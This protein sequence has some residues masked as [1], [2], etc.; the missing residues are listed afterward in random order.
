MRRQSFT[1]IV[2]AIAGLLLALAA[3][4]WVGSHDHN[5]HPVNPGGV[6]NLVAPPF[7][8][9]AYAADE[10]PPGIL[11]DFPDDEVGIAAYFNAGQTIDL[12]DVVGLYRVIETQT[13]DYILGSVPVSG[14]NEQH[15]VHLYVHTSG[16]VMVYLRDTVV[17]AR[18][19][20]WVAYNYGAVIPTKFDSVGT[21]VATTIGIA[22]PTLTYYHFSYPNANRLMLVA[23]GDTGCCDDFQ[24]ELPGTFTYFH[25]SASTWDAEMRLNG[26]T[27][28]GDNGSFAQTAIDPADMPPD[29]LHSF[30]L[31]EGGETEGGVA[32]VYLEP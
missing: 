27:I 12:D 23:D 13:A 1:R 3:V 9:T 6:F 28:I 2:F 4:G 30:Y 7:V 15:D 19:F 25:R 11:T 32:L 26:V 10:T 24:I 20:D 14:Y 8:S 22:P 16:W 17:V 21:D 29:V 18:I 5:A 31:V